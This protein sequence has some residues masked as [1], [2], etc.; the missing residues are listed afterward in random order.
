M[1]RAAKQ[2][3]LVDAFVASGVNVIGKSATPEA[4][5]LPTTEPLA[6]G[7]GLLGLAWADRGRLVP[8][9]AVLGLAGLG[10]ETALVMAIAAGLVV[11]RRTSWRAGAAVALLPV[12]PFGAWAVR[13]RQLVPADTYRS[14]TLLGFLDLPDQ[15]AFDVIACVVTIA[16][17]LV[18]IWRWRDVPVLWLTAAGFLAACA[19]YIGD[20]Y[21][22]HGLPRVSAVGVALGLAAV[23][24]SRPPA[25]ATAP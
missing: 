1:P 13:L 2:D 7:L 3:A 20:Q 22:W 24:P 9:I 25:R 19:F 5:F 17:M 12:L 11:A 21:Q 18:A 6:F 14:T 23:A 15:T 8:A 4:G 16:L 10:R